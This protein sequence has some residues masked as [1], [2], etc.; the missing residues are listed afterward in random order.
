MLAY[1]LQDKY[2]KDMG[3]M[4]GLILSNSDDIP[5]RTDFLNQLKNNQ[6]IDS[7]VLCLIIKIIIIMV[8]YI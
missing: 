3:G 2:P 6:I 7:Y 8:F 4:L 1:T 5:K